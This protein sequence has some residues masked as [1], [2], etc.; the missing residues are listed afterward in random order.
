MRRP[1]RFDLEKAISSWRAFL[2]RQP[3][4]DTEDLDELE[5]HLRDDIEQRRV[6]GHSE[7][8][9]FR[10]ARSKLGTIT[11]ITGSYDMV[12]GDRLF[13]RSGRRIELGMIRDQVRSYAV[14]AART[15]MRSPG[16][17]TLNTI[18]LSFGLAVAL[19]TGLFVRQH[20]TFDRSIPDSDSIYRVD[21]VMSET[22]TPNA[23]GPQSL[24]AWVRENVPQAELVTEFYSVGS[25]Y[26]GQYN[27]E[28]QRFELPRFF[29]VDS[30]FVD[31]FG[32]QIVRGKR[33]ALLSEP[34]EVVLTESTARLLFGEEDP[35]GRTVTR[36]PGRDL[37]VSAIAMDPPEDATLQ[38]SGLTPLTSTFP[39][40]TVSWGSWSTRVFLRIADPASVPAAE[41]VLQ[42][43]IPSN[44]RERGADVWLTPLRD[45]HLASNVQAGHAATIDP[46]IL[47][48]FAG[49]G[50]I[51]L[52]LAGINYVNMATARAGARAREVGIRKVV[53]ATRVQLIRQFSGESV[54][55]TVAALPLAFT[56]AM[57]MSSRIQ[58][59]TGYE[60]DMLR[61]FDLS[62][63]IVF[64]GC[65]VLVGLVAGLYPALVL[66]RF[67]PSR[68]LKSD[69]HPVTGG[70]AL[71]RLLV[72]LQVIVSM[73]LIASAVVT[74]GQLR[75]MA[76]LPAGFDAEQVVV[77]DGIGP[78]GYGWTVERTHTYIQEIRSDASIVGA[79]QGFAPGLGWWNMNTWGTE[80]AGQKRRI[81]QILAAPGYFDLMDIPIVAGRGFRESDGVDSSSVMIVDERL[82]ELLLI[83]WPGEDD[84]DL[85]SEL[86]DVLGLQLKLFDR[87]RT[88]VG[89]VG[90]IR[91]RPLRADEPDWMI[92]YT[93]D[94]NLQP[95]VLA[96]IA[97]GRLSD[98]LTALRATAERMQPDQIFSFSFL[99][100]AI[101]QQYSADRRLARLFALL[102]LVCVAIACLGLIGLA[103]YSAQRRTREIGIRKALGAASWQI[104]TLL[105]KDIVLVVIL[106]SAV[107]IP[108]VYFAARTWLQR[109]SE[110]IE[111]GP[112]IFLLAACLLTV[113]VV[114]SVTVQTIRAAR[115]NP[116]ESLRR[117]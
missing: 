30:G 32:V 11:D 31:V 110:R 26:T 36:F 72:G 84:P 49:V 41:S 100:E 87:P 7:E 96:R 92:G 106:S 102:A 99:D 46:R 40:T 66:S 37:V 74:L 61:Q 53:G 97:A 80:I 44:W 52:L 114:A 70:V 4:L 21:H 17:A 45:I 47:T 57:S 58:D 117:E 83:D 82:A 20:T 116:V 90:E 86:S 112:G 77:L 69:A 104:I 10:K 3:G 85:G 108:V 101:Q 109:F 59:V 89:V 28:D 42:S 29:A 63:L 56:L 98:G 75:H 35:L 79:V 115:R 6:A 50:G 39:E 65:G 103:A 5:T 2:S 95:P 94:G 38:Y 55:M 13:S 1:Y 23:R 71:R 68:A 113:L 16:Y 24:G 54:I 19:L 18:G 48:F 14:I 76:T 88:I 8:E 73:I 25:A 81:G 43:S 22:S 27:V 91:H 105:T 67:R 15:L 51:L 93:P 111:L 9:A 78:R 12:R 33:D 60:F 34:N 62:A 107:G 64:A